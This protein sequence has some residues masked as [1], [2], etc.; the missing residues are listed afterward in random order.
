MR[1]CRGSSDGD[2][3]DGLKRASAT[4]GEAGTRKVRRTASGS[5]RVTLVTGV[6]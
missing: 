2:P 5:E 3:E 4:L 1:S 6:V